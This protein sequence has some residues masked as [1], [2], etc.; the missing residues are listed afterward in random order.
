M[1]KKLYWRCYT[2]FFEVLTLISPRLNS[3]ARFYSKFGHLPNLKAPETF[4]EKLIKLKLEDYNNNP[5]VK[6]C[7]DKY[8][9]REFVADRGL[10][11]TLVRL[12]G[13]YNNPEEIVWDSLPDRF[14]M[15][16]NFG[17][18][19]NIICKDKS[20][21]DIDNCSKKLASWKKDK[22][23]LKNSELQYKVDE[24]QKKIIV[25]EFLDNGNGESPEDIKIYCY[26]GR[27]LY[28]LI[29]SNRREDGTAD[30]CYFDSEWNFKRFDTI[31]NDPLLVS[32]I[33]RPINLDQILSYASVLS[34][35]FP[36]VRVDFYI[37][38]GKIYFG[39]MTFTPCGCMDQAITDE[40][41]KE[42]GRAIIVK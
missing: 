2:R 19:L 28:I 41:N 9:V 3:L 25:E 30:Y 24:S 37:V 10:A 35:G 22:Y 21:L 12:I 14:A 8:A 40:A 31:N 36:F 18:H 38:N 29:C 23:Y 42:L 20:R 16:W 1:I 11:H 17:C 15:K 5:L 39:E 34:S 33:E 7:A 13:V 4:N 26:D 27:P 6:K 32:S